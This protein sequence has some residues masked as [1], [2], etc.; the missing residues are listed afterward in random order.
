MKS[1]F[2]KT[3][4]ENKENALKL[5]KVIMMDVLKNINEHG[6]NKP[7]IEVCVRLDKCDDCG[8]PI[9]SSCIETFDKRTIV[10]KYGELSGIEV[11]EM[12]KENCFYTQE[13][14]DIT[15]I[16]FMNHKWV[17]G[18]VLEIVSNEVEYTRHI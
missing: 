6:V 10:D 17:A 5:M 11:Y 16:F 13:V 2:R 18:M 12:V 3:I 8:K 15:H 9:L 1:T 4:L 14:D 7:L